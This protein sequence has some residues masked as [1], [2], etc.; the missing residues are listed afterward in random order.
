LNSCSL[1]I[2]IPFCASFCDYCDFYSCALPCDDQIE[3]FARALVNDINF[4]LDFFDIKKIKTVYIGGGTPSVLGK[5]IKFLLDALNKKNGFAPEEFT[6]EANPESADEEFLSVCREGGVN[7][8][9]LGVQ[10]FHEPSRTA[11]NRKG[12]ASVLKRCLSLASSFFP[13][14]LSADLMTGLPYQNEKIV[15]DDLK[16]L[17]D[18]NLSHISLYSLTLEK[19]TPLEKKLKLKEV[20]LPDNDSSDS[21]W[22]TARDTLIEEGFLHYEISNF[23]KNKNLCLHNI[24]YWRMEQWLGA[25]P[26]ASGTIIYDEP[27]NAKRF[28]YIQDADLYVKN[29]FLNNAKCEKLDKKTFL[30]DTLLMGFRYFEGPSKELF[31][32]RF[33]L[34]IEECIPK[35][36]FNWKERDK[37]LF[38]NK[39]LSEAF[40]ELDKKEGI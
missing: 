39:F 22:L 31:K 26:G 15:K 3:A 33:G 25:G 19:G 29:P 2:H 27:L 4:Q 11:V 8:L 6:V 24:R 9:S 10:T 23:A 16:R 1:Y 38:L 5:R 28:T 14:S 18:F 35:T 40:M 12:N 36:L 20:L 17:F 30:R 32:K 13:A 37:M 7:R 34:E 21:V